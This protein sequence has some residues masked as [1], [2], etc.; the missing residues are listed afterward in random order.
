M[1]A[2]TIASVLNIIMKFRVYTHLSNYYV[3]EALISPSFVCSSIFECELL[4]NEMVVSI[5]M[6][7]VYV[8]QSVC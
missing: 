8:V 5:M 3:D 1:Y 2:I 4:S 7:G 6:V